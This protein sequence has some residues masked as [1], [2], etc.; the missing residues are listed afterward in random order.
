MWPVFGALDDAP[1]DAIS[2]IN[3]ADSAS[4]ILIRCSNLPCM[5]WRTHSDGRTA[6]MTGESGGSSRGGCVQYVRR[7]LLEMLTDGEKA[8]Y[9]PPRVRASEAPP[10]CP[11]IRR[12]RRLYWCGCPIEHA[13]TL[14]PPITC[15]RMLQQ[16]IYMVSAVNIDGDHARLELTLAT[17]QANES[18]I[19]QRHHQCRA[20]PRLYACCTHG[21]GARLS[22]CYFSWRV[23][24]RACGSVTVPG[25]TCHIGG[26][27]EPWCPNRFE[28]GGGSCTSGRKFVSLPC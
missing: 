5:S 14:I 25:A 3:R 17:R 24:V 7:M 21:Y 19:A 6:G 10:A 26:R 23:A 2:D 15:E 20:Y 8:A 11:W 22:P 16:S 12:L 1:G 28:M 9:P 4:D 18:P 27:H 13:A